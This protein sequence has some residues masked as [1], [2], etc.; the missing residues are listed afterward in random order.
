MQFHVNPNGSS[1][2]FLSAFLYIASGPND[3]EMASTTQ[4]TLGG[5]MQQRV[6][7]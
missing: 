2:G 1:E 4:R 5:T 7:L 6:R 3:D